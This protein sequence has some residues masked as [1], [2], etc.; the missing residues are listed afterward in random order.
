MDDPNALD[1]SLDVSN[2]S[3]N[4]AIADQS[5]IH[6]VTQRPDRQLLNQFQSFRED[7][8]KLMD[9]QKKDIADIKK[10]LEEIQQSNKNIEDSITHLNKQHEEFDKRL[11][12]IENHSKEN[13]EYIMFLEDKLEELQLGSRKTNFELKNVPKKDNED[14]ESLIAMVTCLSETVNCKIERSDIKDIYR[15]RGKNPEQKN[16]PIIIETNS[17]IL[18]TDLI[19]KTKAY[20]IRNRTKLCA[21]H[22]GFKTQEDTPVYLSEHLTAKAARLHFLARDLAKS[23]SYKFCWTAYG[24][25]YVRKSEQSR[26]IQIKTEQQVHHLLAEI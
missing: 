5:S 7:M 24:K 12:L 11:T 21:K 3:N 4:D 22:L 26:I 8:R 20:N 14:N 16:T 23:K 1:M 6:F 18:K 19:K 13:R 25:V 2:V 15:V 10:T 9:L 17:V